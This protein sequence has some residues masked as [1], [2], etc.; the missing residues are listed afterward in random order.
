MDLENQKRVLELTEKYG[1]E[2]IVILL[3]ATEGEASGIAAETVTAGDPT[4]AGPL[5]GVSLGLRVYHVCEP[6][7]KEEYDSAVYEQQCGMMELVLDIDEIISEMST[8][9]EQYTKYYT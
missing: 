3:G 7:M 6:E 1:A 2:N 9:R 5:T 8:I 4:Y